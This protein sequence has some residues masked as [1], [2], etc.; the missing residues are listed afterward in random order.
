MVLPKVLAMKF[1][2]YMDYIQFANTTIANKCN[3]TFSSTTKKPKR[4]NVLLDFAAKTLNY[5]KL[6]M[7]SCKMLRWRCKPCIEV[8]YN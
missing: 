4:I 3:H 6:E 8:H 2:T 5:G 7:G 1:G